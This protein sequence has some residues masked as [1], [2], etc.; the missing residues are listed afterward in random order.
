MMPMFLSM[1]MLGTAYSYINSTMA[2]AYDYT[3]KRT[4]FNVTAVELSPL[5]P[6]PVKSEYTIIN[7]YVKG[8]QYMFHN[9]QCD[10]QSIGSL[11]RQCIPDSALRLTYG[12]IGFNETNTATFQYVV[13]DS[14]YTAAVTIEPRSCTPAYAVFMTNSVVPDSG[15][16]N[17]LLVSDVTPGIKGASIFMPPKICSDGHDIETPQERR[18]RRLL[19]RFTLTFP[20]YIRPN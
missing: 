17:S 19:H 20:F 10:K 9:S 1:L 13:P 7:D 18:M 5:I 14:P 15:T 16:L 8:I 3:N 12:F 11:Q 2:V 4:W 6:K